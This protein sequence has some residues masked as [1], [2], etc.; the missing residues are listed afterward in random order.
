MNNAGDN[1]LCMKAQYLDSPYEI[2]NYNRE[3]LFLNYTVCR[4][5]DVRE[6]HEYMVDQY[7]GKPSDIP[8]EMLFRYPIWSTWA[9]YHADIDQ[10]KVAEYADNILSN[11]FNISQLEIDDNWEY[12]Y[13]YLDFDTEKFPDPKQMVDDLTAVGIRT[14]I[15]I[16]P[17][18]D[19][20]SDFIWVGGILFHYF[21]D[22]G[23]L[24]S[25][26]T[27]HM[28]ERSGYT[29]GLHHSLVKELVDGTA[30]GPEG[31]LRYPFV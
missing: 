27:D 14:T 10:V 24:S 2:H 17:F 22:P 29:R 19:L 4:G 3:L 12:S 21:K 7:L 9:Q 1:N 30:T 6:V 20:N 8:D 11:G 28:V 5:D 26:R 25:P 23:G 31:R 16:H 18:V 13:G 15:W